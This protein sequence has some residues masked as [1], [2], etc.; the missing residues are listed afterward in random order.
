MSLSR[1][2][3]ATP[4]LALRRSR[5]RFR[6]ERGVGYHHGPGGACV[7]VVRRGWREQNMTT[8]KYSKGNKNPE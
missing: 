4:A 3:M 7:E 6:T 1:P 2:G 5:F 8:L